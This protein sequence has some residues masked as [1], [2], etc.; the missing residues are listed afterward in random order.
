MLLQTNS[1]RLSWKKF[2]LLKDAN[3]L[4]HPIS[5]Y[6]TIFHLHVQTQK[7]FYYSKKIAALV[8]N[9]I[10]FLK[11]GKELALLVHSPLGLV[12]IWMR[13]SFLFPV[14]SIKGRIQMPSCGFVSSSHKTK[15]FPPLH[16][17][18]AYFYTW[19]RTPSEQLWDVRR[20]Q[21]GQPEEPTS[22]SSTTTSSQ[23]RPEGT[24]GS[25]SNQASQLSAAH[26]EHS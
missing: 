21:C 4:G 17:S 18:P 26:W 24:C 10:S 12:I 5:L 25:P 2:I 11:K 6:G 23:Q 22:S 13:I 19:V 3:S 16:W 9:N 14:L 7:A 15:C 8:F 20:A 1:F